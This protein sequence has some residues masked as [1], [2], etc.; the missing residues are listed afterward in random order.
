ML[1]LHSLPT[2]A[3]LLSISPARRGFL[4]VNGLFHSCHSPSFAP[5]PFCCNND[6][7]SLFVDEPTQE[8]NV[9]ITKWW[10]CDFTAEHDWSKLRFWSDKVEPSARH[11]MRSLVIFQDARAN[12]LDAKIPRQR[13]EKRWHPLPFRYPFPSVMCH[14]WS[15]LLAFR[16]ISHNGIQGPEKELFVK[17]S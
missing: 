9:Q 17:N 4:K 16:L 7:V 14:N 3:S 8:E 12:L 1:T 10:I 5:P 6:N 13:E 15:P 2:K 11:T